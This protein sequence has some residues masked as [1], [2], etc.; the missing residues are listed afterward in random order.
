MLSRIFWVGIAGFALIAGM[1]VQ[2]GDV[3][4]W[5]DDDVSARA[6]RSIEDRVDRAIDRSFDKMEVVGSDGE[7]VDVPAETKR[8][9]AAA[10]GKLVKAE[11]DFAMA[12]IGEDNEEEMQAASARREEARAEINRL[13]AEIEQLERTAPSDGDALREQIRREVREDIRDSVRDSV[14]S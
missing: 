8:A 3:F 10:V 6:E 9:L 5:G 14:G 12:R 11:T 1:A 2:D 4:S 13:K 7:E